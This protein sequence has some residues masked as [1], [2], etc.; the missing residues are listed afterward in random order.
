MAVGE[1]RSRP[2]GFLP[3]QRFWWLYITLAVASGLALA[4]AYLP[5][6]VHTSTIARVREFRL[7][8]ARRRW[9][10]PNPRA[11]EIWAV[12]TTTDRV[13]FQLRSSA[14]DM[15]VGDTLDLEYTP[16][17]KKV[18]RYRQH[19]LAAHAWWDVFDRDPEYD[20]F[21]ALVL[22]CSL[23]ALCPWWSIEA[24]WWIQGVCLM[25]IAG[26]VFTVIGTD[27]LTPWG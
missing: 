4:D 8:R 12:V 24:H 20:L 11:P 7:P 5:R 16:I 26:W 21:P 27:G 17:W 23:L 14:R 18:Y 13:K 1:G 6:V 9:G 25:M 22:V 19:P 15:P 10:D 2:D 3:R